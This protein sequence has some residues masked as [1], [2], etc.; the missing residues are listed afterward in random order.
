MAGVDNDLVKRRQHR[1]TALYRACA[2]ASHSRIT[3]SARAL[4][5]LRLH[6]YHP[7]TAAPPRARGA[8]HIKGVGVVGVGR[9]CASPW[10]RLIVECL[11]GAARRSGGNMAWN[12]TQFF[13]HGG[14]VEP[15]VN[16]HKRRR[17]ERQTEYYLDASA[18]KPGGNGSMAYA[19]RRRRG[20]IMLTLLT[21]LC[22]IT[23]AVFAALSLHQKK[24][25]KKCCAATRHKRMVVQAM[26]NMRVA[27]GASSHKRHRGWRVTAANGINALA[28]GNASSNANEK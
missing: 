16:K 14:M 6:C 8:A 18:V 19:Q 3:L 9:A 27:Y 22:V 23:A 4:R 13:R 7:A 15:G 10:H 21:R 2:I 28:S 26:A 1:A 24:K 12:G 11:S 5:H 20:H 17:A 25:K